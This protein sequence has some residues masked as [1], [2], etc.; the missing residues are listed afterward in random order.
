MS[1]KREETFYPLQIL[2]APALSTHTHTNNRFL[3]PA[4]WPTYFFWPSNFLFCFSKRLLRLFSLYF[5]LFIAYCHFFYGQ[6]IHFT[7]SSTIFTRRTN[8]NKHWLWPILGWRRKEVC[9]RISLSREIEKARKRLLQH[10][11]THLLFAFYSLFRNPFLSLLYSVLARRSQWT[12]LTSITN[13]N[14]LLSLSLSLSETHCQISLL[15]LKERKKIFSFTFDLQI[16]KVEKRVWTSSVT[17][18]KIVFFFSK[19]WQFA[20]KLVVAL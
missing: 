7:F 19:S 5:F 8:R 16:K 20:M 9:H 13:R 4:L 15:H 14:L 1:T 17:L 18:R 11:H 12:H 10:R 3:F 2:H 6:F